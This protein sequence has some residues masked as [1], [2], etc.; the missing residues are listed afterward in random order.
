M[1]WLSRSV[2]LSVCG[3]NAVDIRDRIPESCRN[4]FHTS[5]VNLESR[6]EITSVG[7]PW[8]LHT[9]LAKITTRPAAAFPSFFKGRK[10]AILVNRSI[11]TLVDRNLPK[12]GEFRDKVHCY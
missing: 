6:S 1:V 12:L 11:I 5:D 7:S 10:C 9:S 8:C 4:S 3:W 2:W